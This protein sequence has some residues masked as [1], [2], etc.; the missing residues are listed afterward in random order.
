VMWAANISNNTTNQYSIMGVT[1]SG[2]TTL[3]ADDGNSLQV[4]QSNSDTEQNH[5][6]AWGKLY[7]GLTAGSNVFTCKYRVTGG[8]ATFLRR[9]LVVIPF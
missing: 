7:T 8:T 4:R 6:V 5:Q 3:A 9:K 2:A 1:I